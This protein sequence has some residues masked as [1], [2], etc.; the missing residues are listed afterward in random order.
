LTIFVWV[1]LVFQVCLF[2]LWTCGLIWARGLNLDDDMRI[3]PL[4][5]LPADPDSP[6]L[7][8]VIA[9]HNEEARIKQCLDLLLGQNYGNFRV[10][11]VDDRSD[12]ET[13][14]RV[15]EIMARDPRVSLVEVKH[16]PEGWIGKTHAM[17]VATEHVDADYLLFIDCDCRIEPGAIA[18]VMRKVLD[19]G[20]AFASLWPSLELRSLSERVITPVAG[21]LLGLWAVLGKKRGEARSEIRLGNGQFMLF[22]REA[23]E[24]M[25]GHASVQAELAEDLIM[26]NKAA[27]LGLKRWIGQGKEMYITTRDNSFT[28]TVDALT[29]VLIG[30]LVTPG[31]ILCS[32]QLLAGGVS[33]PLWAVPIGVYAALALDMNAGWALVAACMLHIAM[34]QAVVR[35]LFALTLRNSPSVLSFVAGSVVC[36]A[37]LYR[38]WLIITGRGSVRW[39]KTTYRVRGSRVVD[40]LPEKGSSLTTS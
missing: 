10:I 39:G 3:S 34:M 18:A 22:S 15:R 4:P 19:D 21:W 2:V 38:A 32:T 7:A 40:V 16:L 37:L 17:A 8:V 6:S 30:S 11:L 23:Y 9:A 36:T 27:A 20:I 26:A 13:S 28:S 5:D 33:S 29:R 25:G 1:V 31:R 35:H 14:P 12:D 24:K